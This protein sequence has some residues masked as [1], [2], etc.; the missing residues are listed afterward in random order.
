MLITAGN[1]VVK[2]ELILH[3]IDAFLWGWHQDL[4]TRE[5]GPGEHHFRGLTN[6]DFNPKRM[7]QLFCYMTLSS[8]FLV[9]FKAVS[10]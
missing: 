6:P 1:V 10:Y 9:L 7:H 3:T 5:P 8:L 4:S 2:F